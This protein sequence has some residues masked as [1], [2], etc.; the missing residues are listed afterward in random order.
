MHATTTFHACKFAGS[1]PLIHVRCH[2]P[3][4]LGR[5]QVSLAEALEL[6]R[7]T[8]D[9]SGFDCYELR[10]QIQIIT[11]DIDRVGVEVAGAS[12]RHPVF[13]EQCSLAIPADTTTVAALTSS[14][15]PRRGGVMTA[16]GSLVVSN[17]SWRK[18]SHSCPSLHTATLDVSLCKLS[19]AAGTPNGARS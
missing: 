4:L 9:A 19:L 7:A 1:A 14:L 11:S 2:W 3:E 17:T 5:G 18:G 6:P 15:G 13:G 16:E 12:R 10:V 8:R